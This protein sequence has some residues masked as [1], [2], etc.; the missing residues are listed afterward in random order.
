MPF[1]VLLS[2]GIVLKLQFCQICERQIYIH[3]IHCLPKVG[4]HA[5]YML[6]SVLFVNLYSP[7]EKGLRKISLNEEQTF[8]FE[9]H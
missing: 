3:L 9:L 5:L 4:L 6:N 2:A 1:W 8:Y 7:K